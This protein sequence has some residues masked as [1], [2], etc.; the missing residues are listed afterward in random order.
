MAVVDLHIVRRAR[1]AAICQ[2]LAADAV[3]D[4]VE[5]RLADLEGVVMSLE[6]VPVIKINGQRVVYPHR[7]KVRNRALVFQ[8][9]DVGEEAGRFLLVAGGYD[10]V[11]E[12]D[13]HRRLLLVWRR[14]ERDGRHRQAPAPLAKR[15]SLACIG[16]NVW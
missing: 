12:N 4:P 14:D 6:V 7:R 8:T 11:I 3:E 1:T 2:P 5:L 16:S 13:G 9:E 10:R 15:R